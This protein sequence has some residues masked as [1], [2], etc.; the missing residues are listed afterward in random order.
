[1]RRTEDRSVIAALA[2]L[3][4]GAVAVAVGVQVSAPAEQ[5]PSCYGASLPGSGV[6][7]GS[8]LIYYL[9]KREQR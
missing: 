6:T 5:V 2:V 1:M 9:S 7:D 4:A 3:D 8:S